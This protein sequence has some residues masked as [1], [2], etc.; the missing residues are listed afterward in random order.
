MEFEI[1]CD[2]SALKVSLK[3]ETSNLNLIEVKKDLTNSKRLI[4][5]VNIEKIYAVIDT[6]ELDRNTNKNIIISNVQNQKSFNGLKYIRPSDL[7]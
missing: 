6:N 7:W 1:Y 3:S 2:E 4:N 5:Y